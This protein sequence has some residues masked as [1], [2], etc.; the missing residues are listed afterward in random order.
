MDGVSMLLAVLVIQAISMWEE[1]GDQEPVKVGNLK[2][3]IV[4]SQT[5]VKGQKLD[6]FQHILFYLYCAIKR[7]INRS[8]RRKC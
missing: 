3:D 4:A 8:E 6:Y 7:T 1:L 2:N 5:V